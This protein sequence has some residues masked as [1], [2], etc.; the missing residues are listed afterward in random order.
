MP[1]ADPE[2]ERACKRESDIRRKDKIAARKKARYWERVDIT[3]AMENERNWRM[4]M[5]AKMSVR[6]Q[7]FIRNLTIVNSLEL[8]RP[9]FVFVYRGKRR[10]EN[11][12]EPLPEFQSA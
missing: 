5:R 8:E 7:E 11:L 3:R 2:R 10:R 6:T 12:R 9:V 4:S 1:Y